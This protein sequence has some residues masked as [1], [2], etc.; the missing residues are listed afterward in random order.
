MADVEGDDDL[1]LATKHACAGRRCTRLIWLHE[2]FC[3]VCRK[4][5]LADERRRKL[6]P[7][8]EAL[9]QNRAQADANEIDEML[10]RDLANL[11]K[12]KVKADADHDKRQRRIAERRAKQAALLGVYAPPIIHIPHAGAQGQQVPAQPAQQG[13]LTTE[14]IM[15]ALNQL[16]AS[17]LQVGQQSEAQGQ[18]VAQLQNAEVQRNQRAQAAQ[19]RRARG[20][21]QQHST[22][23]H[24]I[25]SNRQYNTPRDEAN[26]IA[27]AVEGH[28]PPELEPYNMELQRN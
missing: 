10:D 23:P 27:S 4:A 22:V 20:Q 17:I 3:G 12:A 16:N 14:A 7:V 18:V 24:T 13:Q 25:W 11:E 2:R 28:Q 5:H 6:A 26:A 15:T 21:N 8:R 9:S 1:P 19:E